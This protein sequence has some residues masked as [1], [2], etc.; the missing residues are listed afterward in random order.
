MLRIRISGFTVA[1][2]LLISLAGSLHARQPNL[3]VILTDDQ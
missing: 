1:W 3:V 2:L